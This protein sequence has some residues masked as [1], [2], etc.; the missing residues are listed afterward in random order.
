MQDYV[1]VSPVGELAS[2]RSLYPYISRRIGRTAVAF[3]ILILTVGVNWCGGQVNVVTQR[4]DIGRTGQNTSES[5]LAPANVNSSQFGRLFAFPVDGQIYAQ[6]LYLS[7]VQIPG[8]GTHNVIFVATEHDS[9]YSFDADSNGGAHST[10]L[11]QASLLST[12][13]GAAAGTTTVSSLEIADDIVPEYGITGTPVIDPVAGI[14]YVVS[15]TQEGTNFVLRLH[16][17]SV[18]T[19]VEM[20]GGPVAIQA[21]VP[22]TGNG[23]SG[24]VLHFDP[25]WENQRS[26][27]L[28]LNGI[29][30][31]GFA[32][33][34]DNGDW[35][36]WILS[37]NPTTLAQ[38]SAYC[39]SPNGVGSGF[40]MG[41]DGLAADVVDP[42]GHPFGRM[43]LASGNGD[44]NV[45]APYTNSMDYGD[46]II[47]L[48]LTN[49]SPSIQ[50]EFTPFNQA[51][52]DASDGDL[53]SGG[54]VVLP[55]QAGPN[56]HLL[57]QE[58]KNGTLYL[59]NRDQMGGYGS[60]DNI[61]QQ[62]ASTASGSGI[63]GGPASWH[64]NLYIGEKANHLKA[65]SLANG[66]LSATPT[67][68]SPEIFGF[69][70]PSPAVSS[71]GNTNGIVWAVETDAFAT[72]GV[73][74]LR[75]YNATNL[76]NELYSSTQIPN[77][78]GAGTAAKFATPTVANGKVYVGTGSELDVYG[79]LSSE[80]AIASPVI[81]PGS[82]TFTTSIQVTI[83]DAT[84][85]AIIYYTADGS[86]PSTASTSY[87]GPITVNSTQTI[88]AIAVA[89]GYVWIAPVSA[90][91]TSL[92]TTAT[93]RFSP[94]GGT[95]STSPMVK[96]TDASAGASIYYTT[97]GSTPTNAS[98]LYIGP[99]AVSGSETIAAI[100]F[101]PGLSGSAIASQIYTTQSQVNFSNGF[102]ESQSIMTF[103][104]STGLD[105]SRLQLTNGYASETG[106]AFLTK[107]LN[108]QAF[109]TD[110]LFQLSNPQAEGITFMIQGY[111]PTAIGERLEVWAPPPYRIASR[112]SST[113][114]IMAAKGPTQPA[115]ISTG[116]C[117][118]YRRSTFRTPEL[119]CSAAIR[120]RSTSP[121][122][123]AISP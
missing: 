13:H 111:K 3:L 79:L 96:I 40:W 32:S 51:A 50:D 24:G 105:D 25:K 99:I 35:H 87:T 78:D 6:P 54:V 28:L 106:T 27:L 115:S 16:A 65:Y 2:C 45:S 20:L 112:S 83:T 121:T 48:D 30:Y 42:V 117:P 58:G 104:G 10:P 108:V 76:A 34:A 53:G 26:G 123:A 8:S 97:D 81:D 73:S 46:S 5:V 37:Y 29:L 67:S 69:P 22:G 116:R 33:H 31:I 118:R 98:N 91:F 11:W 68:L 122:T 110:F 109:T 12:A 62:V 92:N 89:A 70:G 66:T 101:A 39:S 59:V 119:I 61:V 41:G 57:A 93:P 102:S 120:W 114:S 43:F 23:S 75:A 77:R 14:L 84:P 44:Y 64:G 1:L 88:K 95:F 4:N 100:A 55:N 94:A 36:G 82:T 19:G 90:T 80:P 85:G 107:P 7:G 71:L 74:V 52:L 56:P 103:N 17:L 63:W 21:Q 9:V 15:F 47:N 18:T 72:G 113:S 49:G 38:I 86:A 60:S